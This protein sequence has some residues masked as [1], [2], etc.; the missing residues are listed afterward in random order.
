MSTLQYETIDESSGTITLLLK[1]PP[2]SGKTHK[3]ARFPKPVIFNFDNNL[4]GL[5]SLPAEVKKEIR[6]VNPRKNAKGE[7]IPAIAIWDN[8]VAQL[9]AVVSDKTVR[10]VVIDSLSS[11]ANA[12]EDK[13]LQSSSPALTFKLQQWGDFQR[14]LKWLGEELMNNQSRHFNVV[15]IAH[16]TVDKDEATQ[17]V[18]YSL[19][20]GGRMK[21]SFDMFFSDCWRCYTR[22][23]NATPT[24]PSG[25]EFRVRTAP[26]SQFNA[27]LSL[28]NVPPDF[29]WDTDSGKVLSQLK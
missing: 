26:T 6:V 12:L 28:P 10:T 21:N 19:N 15:V 18:T 29:N 25:V 2:G 4:S 11:L 23:V 24:N 17:A 3:A 9:T 13:I 27:K 1:G 8:F 22:T 20:V 5:R 14:Y 7:D 16:E